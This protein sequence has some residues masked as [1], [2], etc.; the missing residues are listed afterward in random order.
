MFRN[1]TCVTSLRPSV[2]YRPCGP[3]SRLAEAQAFQRSAMSTPGRLIVFEGPDSVGKSTLA[4]EVAAVLGGRGT[5]CDLLAFPG[6]EPGTLGHHVHQLHHDPRR[7]GVAG[8]PPASLQLLHVAAHV[9][10]VANRILP[11]LAA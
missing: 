4:R 5:P 11:A 1:D 3:P 2:P 8:I 6:R 9:D 7:F 10:A